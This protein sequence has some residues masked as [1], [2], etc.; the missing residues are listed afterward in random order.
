MA[1]SRPRTDAR[2]TKATMAE[3]DK[4]QPLKQAPATQ[5][6]SKEQLDALMK[7]AEELDAAALAEGL[8]AELLKQPK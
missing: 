1:S 3:N 5:K 4:P 6:I 8:A 2:Y 7:K